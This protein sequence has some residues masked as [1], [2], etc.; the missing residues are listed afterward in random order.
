LYIGRICPSWI[1]FTDLQAPMR[2]L[3]EELQGL[4]IVHIS[5]LH[6]SPIV[7]ERYL[8]ECIDHVNQL[9][10][11]FVAVT[12]DFVTGGAQ[13]AQIAARACGR[14]K[15]RY[16]TLA[17]LGNHDYGRCHPKGHGHMRHLAGF[18]SRRL[19]ENGVH[20]LRNSHAVFRVDGKP[21]QFVGL[22]DLWTGLFDPVGTYA[23]AV[24]GLPTITLCHNPDAAPKLWNLGAEWVLAGHT[25]GSGLVAAFPDS[26]VPADH[27]DFIGG[28]YTNGQGGHMYVNR[29]MGYARRTNINRRPEI[30]A[31]TLTAA[32]ENAARPNRTELVAT[33]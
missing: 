18:L 16:A 11:D 2:N 7:L 3:P 17:C 30:T 10:P 32:H 25:H 20:V 12:G 13:F 21:I 19:F 4:R 24:H 23:E 15:A 9:D 1:R 26:L 28:Y 5:D 27:P 31:L 14:I 8:N 22:E 33:A 29:G 6:A